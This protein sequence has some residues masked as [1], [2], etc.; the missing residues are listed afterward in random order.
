[1]SP[2]PRSHRLR[3]PRGSARLAR[4]LAVAL[5][6]VT[7]LV[8]CAGPEAPVSLPDDPATATNPAREPRIVTSKQVKGRMWDLTVDSPAVGRNVPVRLLLPARYETSK[9]Q[10]F[11]VL[12]LFHGCCDTYESWTKATDIEK[13]TRNLDVL[14]VMPDGGP[15]GF[16]SNWRSGPAWET[17]HVDELGLLLTTQYRASDRRVVAGLSMGGLGALSYAARHPGK[18]SVAASFS[19]I[20]H[21]RLSSDHEQGYLNLVSS[22]GEDPQALWG[23]PASDEDTWKAH[24]PYDLASRLAGTKLF[25]SA[26]NGQP[27]PLDPA[28]AISDEIEISIGEENEAFAK[29][30]R[31]LGLDA[32]I[33]LYGDGTHNWVYWQ[34]ELDR[35]WPLITEGLGLK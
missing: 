28:G 9:S 6:G 11:P 23:D 3:G 10:R 35:A 1:M 33:D 14:V 4:R 12:Y 34:R 20:V 29:R 13:R 18:F 19:G 8:A 17:F 26:G 30:L 25:V 7:L 27:G 16:Y 32:Q 15:V 5:L 31:E 22:Q 21:T 2:D 24:N